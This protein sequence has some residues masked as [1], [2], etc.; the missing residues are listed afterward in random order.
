[1]NRGLITVAGLIANARQ[2][3]FYGK[4]AEIEH[5]RKKVSLFTKGALT[6]GEISY[7]RAVG[8]QRH[9]NCFSLLQ[10]FSFLAGNLHR[11]R[12]AGLFVCLFRGARP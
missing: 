10:S 6:S 3:E 7:S 8:K 12:N 1:M 2:I 9:A 5:Q 11:L 4:R